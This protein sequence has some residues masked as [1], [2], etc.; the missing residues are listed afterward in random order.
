M[1]VDELLVYPRIV[2]VDELG[3]PAARP[4]GEWFTPRRILADPLR[5]A[6]VRRYLPGDNPRHVH[7]RATAR[8]G[9]LQVKV[10]D[11]SASLCLMIVVDVQTLPRNYEYLPATLEYVIMA[12]GS[13]AMHALDEHYQVGLYANALT[14][15]A[16]TWS[17]V[18]PSGHERQATEL[19]SAL[20]ALEPFRG[21]P[22]ERLLAML[23]PD[24]PYGA[25]VIAITSLLRPA[26][27]EALDAVQQGGHPVLLLTASETMPYV[28]DSI[29]SFHLGEQGDWQGVSRI[30][31]A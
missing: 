28:P 24:L 5:Y 25:S 20:A 6:G 2:P 8:T 23:L 16:E 10:F 29:P 17:H 4:M 14:R 7:W 12:A 30:A 3:L 27:V 26:A 31:L 18:R 19:L 21:I 11:A 13:I 9:Q 22:L 15:Q 1:R